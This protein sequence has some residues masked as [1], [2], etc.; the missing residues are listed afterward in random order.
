MP[1]TNEQMAPEASPGAVGKKAGVRRVNN[2]PMYIIGGVLGTFLLMMMLVAIDRASQQGISEEEEN[3]VAANMAM[4]LGMVGDREGLIPAAKPVIPEMP[5][6]QPQEI[7]VAKP[8]DPETAAVAATT[9]VA[10]ALKQPERDE[11]AEKIRAAKFAMFREAVQSKSE[12]KCRH[13]AVQG[14]RYKQATA[15]HVTGMRWFRRI[16]ALRRGGVSNRCR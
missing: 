6:G 8:V 7:V 2:M 14:S 11:E 3:P 1:E 16:E 5:K 15:R 10:P 9:A 12:C 13:P 4:A